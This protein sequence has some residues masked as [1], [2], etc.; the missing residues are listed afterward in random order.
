MKKYV[1]IY[2]TTTATSVDS[3]SHV[4][5]TTDELTELTRRARNGA[6]NYSSKSSGPGSGKKKLAIN[7]IA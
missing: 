7:P 6:T 4:R 2:P 3:K 5:P 1:A